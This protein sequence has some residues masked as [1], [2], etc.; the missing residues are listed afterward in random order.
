[1]SMVLLNF[2]IDVIVNFTTYNLIFDNGTSIF[3]YL[4]SLSD[5]YGK[6]LFL[7]KR[8]TSIILASYHFLT[9]CLF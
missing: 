2:V 7:F 8:I 3:R 6:V 9:H 5:N 1:M 4:T